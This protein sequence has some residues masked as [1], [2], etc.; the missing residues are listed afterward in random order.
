MKEFYQIDKARSL[1]EAKEKLDN[2]FNLA[3]VDI[4]LSA[5][6]E[7]R[8]GIELSK[9]VKNTFPQIKIIL[10]SAYFADQEIETTYDAFIHKPLI[11]DVLREKVNELITLLEKNPFKTP[12]PFE[13]LLG[14]LSGAFSKR[15]NITHRLVY[16]VYKKEKIVKIIRMWTHYE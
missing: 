2:S 3:I 14:D 4:R 8:D 10:V 7:N 12:P 5:D 11:E 13:K 9:W 16:Q 1:N 15:I 6:K